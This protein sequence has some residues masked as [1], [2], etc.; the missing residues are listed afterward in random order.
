[1]RASDEV[2]QTTTSDEG[3]DM[4]TSVRDR[5]RKLLAQSGDGAVTSAE[6]EAF[7]AKAFELMAREGLTEA[8]LSEQDP[9]DTA[10]DLHIPYSPTFARGLRSVAA[11]LHC[12]CIYDTSGKRALLFGL[13]RHLERLLFLWPLLYQVCAAHS[14]RMRGYDAGHTRRKRASFVASFFLSVADRLSEIEYSTAQEH[15]RAAGGASGQE[16]DLIGDAQRAKEAADEWLGAHGYHVRTTTPRVRHDAEG[17]A[18]GRR[19]GAVVDIGQAR[20]DAPR[21]AL[22]F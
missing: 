9:E 10:I 8:E 5:I 22:P 4:K 7:R 1:M 6:A 20:F 17:L 16:L 3:N 12:E 15:N 18:A 14:V 13:P 2:W 11:A 19:A 21:A